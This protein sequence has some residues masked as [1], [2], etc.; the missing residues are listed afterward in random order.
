M[1]LAVQLAWAGD[2][3][4]NASEEADA[5]RILF[6]VISFGHSF[7][8]IISNITLRTTGSKKQS[9]E[10]AALFAVRVHAIVR[11]F[12]DHGQFDPTPL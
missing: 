1:V 7:D 6:I 2:A 8:S 4:S 3:A 5:I 10:G 11:P 9:D 12:R